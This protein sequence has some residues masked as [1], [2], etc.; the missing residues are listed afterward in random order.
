MPNSHPFLA[1][2]RAAALGLAVLSGMTLAGCSST[3]TT[4]ANVPDGLTVDPFLWQGAIETLS[5]LPPGTQDPARGR[6]VTGWGSAS[7]N[8]GE[9]VR[10]TVQIYPG[11]V[12]AASVEVS[13][14]RQVNG[15]AAGVDPYTPPAVSEA[16]LLR[17]RQLR[18]NLENY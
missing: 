14:E 17:A 16:I 7:G 18:A 9:L 4:L 6:I 8:A 10:V 12:N 15:A 5:F 3:S 13:V 2:T 1:A 11:P